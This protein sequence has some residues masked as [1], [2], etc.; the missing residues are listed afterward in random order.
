MSTCA[1]LSLGIAAAKPC[2]VYFP[3]FVAAAAQIVR[4][5]GEI[6]GLESTHAG[7]RQRADGAGIP[8]SG[9]RRGGEFR[10]Y[11]S[12]YLGGRDGP[13][14]PELVRKYK[15]KYGEGPIQAF[16]QNAYDGMAV[17]LMAIKR[18]R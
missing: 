11:K 1:R 16:H 8:G 6:E 2:V 4:Q 10:V 3:I 15:E 12:G 17:A 5:F 7:R 9:G 14:Y 13:R 18:W